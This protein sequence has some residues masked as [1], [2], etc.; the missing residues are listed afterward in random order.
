MSIE[1]PKT[2]AAA[3]PLMRLGQMLRL[4]ETWVS[5]GIILLLF[6]V[7][8]FVRQ[9]GYFLAPQFWVE[10]GL[11]YYAHA[12]NDSAWAAFTLLFA[13][14]WS[15]FENLWALLTVWLVPMEYAALSF[16]LGGLLV[17]LTA[18]IVILHSRASHWQLPWAKSLGCLIVLLTPLSDEL[19]VSPLGAKFY[20]SLT[21]ALLLL[22][23]VSGL[24]RRN[25]ILFWALLVIGAL[26]SPVPCM[27]TPFFVF[28]WWL[29]RSPENGR[30]AGWMAAALLFHLVIMRLP[31]AGLA[32]RQ[33]EPDLV[34]TI[35]VWLH[36]C[37]LLP[38][39]GSK[40]AHV[41]GVQW[42]LPA[43]ERHAAWLPALAL[44]VL[45]L[46]AVL[47]ALVWRQTRDPKLLLVLLASLTLGFA[48]LWSA[49]GEKHLMLHPTWAPRYS[50]TPGILLV[51]VLLHVALNPAGRSLALR[52][53]AGLL[54][55]VSLLSGL[56]E[57][58]QA[59][60][61]MA[62]ETTWAEESRQ[63]QADPNHELR[64]WPPPHKFKLQPR[65]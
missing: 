20:F 23:P 7:A 51:L 21:F 50:L 31:A 61:Y 40:L 1:N 62:Q 60:F 55:S 58:R 12:W 30:R 19:W 53:A 42:L 36:K 54:V 52:Y 45:V 49:V 13:G 34:G 22:E 35:L 33:I 56:W 41:S 47:V 9:P 32:D 28:K 59:R 38:L 27:L 65:E 44:A 14:Y 63:W 29:D 43:V 39:F 4:P 2:T 25:R 10:E 8:V 26:T 11:V 46:P 37:I 3:P 64:I 15:C 48:S 17:M 18:P 24:S 16:K 5:R 57:F 6:I